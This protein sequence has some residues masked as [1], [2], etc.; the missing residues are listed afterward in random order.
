MEKQTKSIDRVIWHVLPI[1]LN[2]S[3]EKERNKIIDSFYDTLSNFE[4]KR[5]K[6][7]KEKKR[8][9]EICLHV[10]HLDIPDSL[11]ETAEKVIQSL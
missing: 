10:I 11:K 5:T 9:K 8:I 2:G 3:M 1:N 4:V 6:F 7:E